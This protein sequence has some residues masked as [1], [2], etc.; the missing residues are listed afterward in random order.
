MDLHDYNVKNIEETEY[1]E[2]EVSG[3]DNVSAMASN[4]SIGSS[5]R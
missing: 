4:N 3:D 2:F 5:I 1:D